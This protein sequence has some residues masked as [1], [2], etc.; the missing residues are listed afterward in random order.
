MTAQLLSRQS[1]RAVLAPVRAPGVARRVDRRGRR[2]GSRLLALRFS[3]ALGLST[4]NPFPFGEV[5]RVV[6]GVTI[7]PFVG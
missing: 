6:Q 5:N 1:L 2:L 4:D 7:H 3:L